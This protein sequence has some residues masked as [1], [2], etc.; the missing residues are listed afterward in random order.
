MSKK[1][2]KKGKIKNLE[3]KNV[4]EDV[5]LIR[6]I[7]PFFDFSNC[8]G[9]LVLPKEGRNSNAIA[10]DLNI[11]PKLALELF[12][13]Y[14]HV[15]EY[16]VCHAD[17]NHCAHVYGWEAMEA[18][19]HAPRPE[20][21]HL[22]DLYNYYNAYFADITDFGTIEAFADLNGYAP[23]KKVESFEPGD[24]L[25]FD[26]LEILTISFKAHSEGF[27]GL[28]LPEEK[29]LHISSL[30]FDQPE[31]EV[32]GFGPWYGNKKC[33]L[34]Q[35]QKDIDKAEELFMEEAEFLTSSQGYIVEKGDKKPFD[36]MRRK[37]KEKQQLINESLLTLNLSTD[38]EDCVELLLDQDL[39][40][41]KRKMKGLLRIVHTSWENWIIRNHLQPI[42]KFLEME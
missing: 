33:S 6:Q 8:N 5:L 1:G 34:E 17:M 29:I 11:E 37:I 26:N 18:N 2:E 32:D 4:T 21:M 3:I 10:L 13:V 22:I 23:C 28:Y 9:L 41:N 20:N 30:G 35:Y 12:K 19:I 40:F 7:K 27:V 31:P 14:G 42:F 36:Y 15:S 39:F 38:F 25:K 24:T 16:V